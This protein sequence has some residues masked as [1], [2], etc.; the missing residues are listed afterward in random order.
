MV[1]VMSLWLPILV[2]AVIVFVA[3][4]IIHMVLPYHR[5]NFGKV[6]AED[7]VM[8][9]LR[10]F[11]IPAGDYMLPSAGSPDAMKDPAY[12]AKL[13]QGPV[14]LMT[15]LPS[16]GYT[17]GRNL[18]VWFLFCLGVSV[19]AAY[20]TGRAVGAGT[21]YLEVFRFA[22][23]T[24]FIAYALAQWQESIWHQRKWSTTFKH[25][26]DGLVFGLLTAG[27]FGW[28]WPN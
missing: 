1:T 8:E 4:A 9:A 20:V 21:R 27:T 25:T 11:S 3:S 22:G 28:L 19:I 10:K 15:V 18:F 26:F 2:S 13:K 12:K 5:S 16:G 6:P 7:G 14:V 17:M 24:S 23:V